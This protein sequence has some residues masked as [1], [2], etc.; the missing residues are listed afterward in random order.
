MKKIFTTLMCAVIAGASC[1]PSAAHASEVQETCLFANVNN[2]SAIDALDASLILTDY[3][4]RATDKDSI[5][6]EAQSAAADVSCDGH[7]DAIDASLVLGY[8]AYKAVGGSGEIKEFLNADDGLLWKEVY[9]QTVSDYVVSAYDTYCG[10]GYEDITLEDIQAS[11]KFALIC[12]DDDDIPE[13]IVESSLG[14]ARYGGLFTYL[15]GSAYKVSTYSGISWIDYIERSGIYCTSIS[16]GSAYAFSALQLKNI[17]SIVIETI[18]V[19]GG[20]ATLNNVSVELDVAFER[21][22]YYSSQFATI[23]YSTITDLDSVIDEY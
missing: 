12:V 5:F 14:G 15:N 9:K 17:D 4:C 18:S 11:T 8:Y 16:A 21:E 22:E 2:D 7:V 19:I 13:L 23:T 6:N 10:W 20:S 1:L 3:A